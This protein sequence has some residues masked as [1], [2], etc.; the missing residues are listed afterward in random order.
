MSSAASDTSPTGTWHI[1]DMEMGDRDYYDVDT[2][3]YLL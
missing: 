3:P 2:K 1:T